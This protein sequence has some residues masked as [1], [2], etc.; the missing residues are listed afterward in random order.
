[1]STA[2]TYK[3]IRDTV[4][5]HLP[6]ARVV[7]FGSRARGDNDTQSDYDLLIILPATLTPK[8]KM[9]WRNC[10][11][12]ALVHSINAPV[13]VLINSEE[14]VRQKQQLPGHVIQYAMREGI[15]L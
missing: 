11:D 13:D 8:E 12:H 7:L 4:E 5:A 14:E 3:Q 1:V 9:K 10:L 15:T 6:D 2:T